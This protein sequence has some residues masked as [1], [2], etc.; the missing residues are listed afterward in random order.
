MVHTMLGLGEDIM[1][2][3]CDLRVFRVWSSVGLLLGRG[4]KPARVRTGADSRVVVT[5]WTDAFAAPSKFRSTIDAF[6]RQ[7]STCMAYR[8]KIRHISR[9]INSNSVYDC[10]LGS[11][12]SRITY[13]L[14]SIDKAIKDDRRCCIGSASKQHGYTTIKSPLHSS[15]LVFSIHL[16][17]PDQSPDR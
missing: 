15:I 16:E 7:A 2:A 9:L 5:Q 3:R 6:Q 8:Y 11:H 10:T 1:D 17:S 13:S 4:G 14:V 12:M